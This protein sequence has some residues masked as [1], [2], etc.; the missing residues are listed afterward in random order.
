MGLTSVIDISTFGND[1]FI[2]AFTPDVP[3]RQ[4]F[5]LGS[6][7]TDPLN[8]AEPLPPIQNGTVGPALGTCNGLLYMGWP[9]TQQPGQL[10]LEASQVNNSPFNT[11]AISPFGGTGF[12]PVGGTT[13]SSPSIACFNA[14][15]Y[16]AWIGFGNRL[17]IAPSL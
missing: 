9:A 12:G 14:H 15:I 5:F 16:F 7:A 13:V 10:L 8:F 11:P 3:G 6:S 1:S 17:N 4:M 2:M